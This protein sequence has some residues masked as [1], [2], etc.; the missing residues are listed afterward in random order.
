MFLKAIMII[1]SAMVGLLCVVIL[2]FL[3][4]S[5]A[6]MV[7]ERLHLDEEGEPWDLEIPWREENEYPGSRE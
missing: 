6:W 3:A 1:L 4:Y 7:H 2:G 5:I